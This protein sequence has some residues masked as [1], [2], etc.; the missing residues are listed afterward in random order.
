MT[1]LT[2]DKDKYF[3]FNEFCLA[4]PFKAMNEKEVTKISSKDDDYRR[5]ARFKYDKFNEVNRAVR[6]GSNFALESKT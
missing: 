4:E 3:C 5:L 6:C 2:L 1:I